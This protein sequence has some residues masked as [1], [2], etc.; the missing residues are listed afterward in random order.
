MDP[1]LV[2]RQ[3]LDRRALINTY[4]Q[5]SPRLYCY[6]VRLLGDASLAEECVSETFCRYLHAIKAGRGP[7]ISPQAYLYRIAHNWITDFYRQRRPQTE[8]LAD[9]L[10]ADP[11]DD[12]AESAIQHFERE[13]VRKA[14]LQLTADQQ[15][16]ISL[17][18]L[19]DF[20]TEEIA[21]IVGK[22]VEACKMLQYRALNALQGLL[23]KKQE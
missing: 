9:D 1:I 22:T 13:R 6:A 20:S 5:Y 8:P 16:V 17:R 10:P 15:Q 2:K 14:L 3:R 21:E 19:D 11:G 12:P 4:E 7:N 18:F 23:N